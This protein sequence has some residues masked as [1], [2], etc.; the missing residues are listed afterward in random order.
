[1][2]NHETIALPSP[3]TQA[4]DTLPQSMVGGSNVHA[5]YRG[6]SRSDVTRYG[7]PRPSPV[8]VHGASDW[9][10]EAPTVGLPGGGR[11]RAFGLARGVVRLEEARTPS[12]HSAESEPRL[13]SARRADAAPPSHA[14]RVVHA[15]PSPTPQTRRPAGV[16]TPEARA[17]IAP[18]PRHDA[19]TPFVRG[20]K[21][22]RGVRVYR[23]PADAP[24]SAS[25]SQKLALKKP[26]PKARASRQPTVQYMPDPSEPVS[27]G[28]AGATLLLTAALLT[29]CIAG[30]AAFQLLIG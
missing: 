11:P 25:H 18:N 13:A 3:T 29:G 23:V 12:G 6:G 30:I 16:V 2:S 14:Q 21:S 24:S 17:P 20:A 8:H 7:A 10:D 22:S 19:D 26:S 5:V 27:V 15:P 4:E 9:P 28:L 1:M